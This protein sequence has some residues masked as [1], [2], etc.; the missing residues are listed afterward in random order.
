VT[1]EAA[2]RLVDYLFRD[3]NL[4]FETAERAFAVL[5]LTLSL[6][7]KDDAACLHH[8]LTDHTLATF[9]DELPQLIDFP[10]PVPPPSTTL[11]KKIQSLITA[12]VLTGSDFD[13]SS[14]SW[15]LK[16]TSLLHSFYSSFIDSVDRK[17]TRDTFVAPHRHYLGSLTNPIS[18]VTQFQSMPVQFNSN[19]HNAQLQHQP[20]Q[21]YASIHR[22]LFVP[23]YSDGKRK[24]GR[25]CLSREDGVNGDQ[26]AMKREKKAAA[27][28]KKKEKKQ[29]KKKQEKEV[30]EISTRC[31]EIELFD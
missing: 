5:G 29:E 10:P 16:V 22:R 30:D 17:V 15:K 26:E 3:L 14:S 18:L 2:D 31:A 27:N 6:N 1:V 23:L 19:F 8:L 12:K 20:E 4:E 7:A 13:H 25:H 24:E 21:P 11:L 28:R 9:V